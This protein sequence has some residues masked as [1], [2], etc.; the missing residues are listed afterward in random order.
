MTNIDDPRNIITLRDAL[1]ALNSY[2]ANDND[3]LDR[4]IHIRDMLM[5]DTDLFDAPAPDRELLLAIFNALDIESL[6]RLRLDYSLCPMHAHD[7]A[8]CFDDDDPDCA[9]IRAYFPNHDT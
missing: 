4:F 1:D 5:N 9:T 7:Y 8:I 2:A 3:D 6:S